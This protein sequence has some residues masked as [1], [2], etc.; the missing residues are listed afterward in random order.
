MI[1]HTRI[2]RM[3]RTRQGQSCR[4]RQVGQYTLPPLREERAWRLFLLFHH[5]PCRSREGSKQDPNQTS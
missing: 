2:T 5:C 1:E 4:G 3:V